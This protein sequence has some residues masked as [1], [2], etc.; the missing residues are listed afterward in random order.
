MTSWLKAEATPWII[1]IAGLL[2]ILAG[3]AVGVAVSDDVAK[4]LAGAGFFL[5]AGLA[6]WLRY[7]KPGLTR[8]HL[9]KLATDR[10]WHY[11]PPPNPSIVP[12][13]GLPFSMAGRHRTLDMVRGTVNGTEFVILY[14]RVKHRTRDADAVEHFTVMAAHVDADLPVTTASPRRGRHA[15]ASAIGLPELATESADFNDR[16]RITAADDRG[17]MA[18]IEPRTMERMMKADLADLSVTWDANAV[19]V[20]ERGLRRD[21]TDID[22]TLTA[23][24]DLAAMVPTYYKRETTS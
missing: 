14:H 24:T 15:I 3:G 7:G 23:L 22:S 21:F 17:G 18:I 13:R 20:I 2:G 4:V 6:A 9:K 1:A 10:G 11:S 16:W 8:H 12:A 19:M 5:F